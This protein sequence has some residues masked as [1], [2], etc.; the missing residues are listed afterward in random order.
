MPTIKPPAIKVLAISDHASLRSKLVVTKKRRNSVVIP[1]TAHK[2]P[3]PVTLNTGEPMKYG[4][5]ATD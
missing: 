2:T 5:T 4:S 3:V 1:I